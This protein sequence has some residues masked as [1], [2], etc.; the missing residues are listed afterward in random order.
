[1]NVPFLT[2]TTFKGKTVL[3]RT[4]AELYE[5]AQKGCLVICSS[6][7]KLQM[8]FYALKANKTKSQD[9]LLLNL[10]GTLKSPCLLL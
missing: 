4:T 9:R 7:A 5:A 2:S 10:Q 8:D 6:T 3:Q 1:M